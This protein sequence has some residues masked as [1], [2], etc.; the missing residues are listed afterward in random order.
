MDETRKTLQVDDSKTVS[1]LM[2]TICAKIGIT[3]YEE[4]SLIRPSDDDEKMRT[5]TLRK[6][7]GSIKNL[8]K[9]EKMKQKLH[10]DDEFN[11]LA[12]GKTLRQHGVDE[13]EILLL[14]RKYFYSDQN[15]DTRDPVQ[16]NLLYVQLKEAILNGTHPI[17]QDQAINLAALQCQVEYGPMVPEKIKRNPIE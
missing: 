1:E 16:L 5:L 4:Y 2:F 14:R 8:E 6:S 7:R 9:L 3:N 10:T 12:P 11:W 15:I 13:S 17:S